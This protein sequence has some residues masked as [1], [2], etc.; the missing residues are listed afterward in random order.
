[1][2]EDFIVPCLAAVVLP[3][4]LLIMDNEP[5]H[6]AKKAVEWY[7]TIYARGRLGAVQLSRH[8]AQSGRLQ[9]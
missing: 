7:Q 1:M 4:W 9:P 3:G 6:E 2:I 8:Q 5:S